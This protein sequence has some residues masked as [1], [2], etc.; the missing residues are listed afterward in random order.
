MDCASTGFRWGSKLG[1]RRSLSIDVDLDWA[2]LEHQPTVGAA[3]EAAAVGYVTASAA[4]AAALCL[5]L[6]LEDV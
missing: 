3:F 2:E 1:K 4:R 6:I 5:A